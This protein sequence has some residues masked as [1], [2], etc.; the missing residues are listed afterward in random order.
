MNKYDT[1]YITESEENEAAAE[2]FFD[3]LTEIADIVENKDF[4]RTNW[5][6]IKIVI[7][8]AGL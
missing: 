7:E 4:N 1:E 8:K 6:K 5:N 3:A 2:I